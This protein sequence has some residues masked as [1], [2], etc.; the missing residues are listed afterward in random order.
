MTLATDKIAREFTHEWRVDKVEHTPEGVRYYTEG[1]EFPQKGIPTK[2]AQVALGI[3]KK[4]FASWV[5]LLKLPYFYPALLCI[6]L[7]PKKRFIQQVVE[8]INDIGR[9]TLDPYRFPPQE[10]CPFAQSFGAFIVITL[11]EIGVSMEEA[12]TFGSNIALIFDYDQSYRWRFQDIMEET[13]PEKLFT[14]GELERLDQIIHDRDEERMYLQMH[15]LINL[16]HILLLSPH[17][18]KSLR[19]AINMIHYDKL[20]FDEA[21]RYWCCF[22]TDYKFFGMS[23]AA[24]MNLIKEKGWKIPISYEISHEL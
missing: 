21:D 6:V 9:V 24:R 1:A 18:K 16:L 23:D 7:L 3:F 22:R 14:H 5:R 2:E 19:K 8:N 15:K 17:I 13:N 4:T 10:L 11:V 12:R 20:L